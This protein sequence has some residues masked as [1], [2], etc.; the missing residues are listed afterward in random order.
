M[1]HVLNRSAG[2]FNFFRS[3]KDFEAFHCLIVEAHTLHPIRILSYCILSNHWHF[4]VWPQHDGE[5][6]A[7]F[8]WLA[9]TH[10]MRWRV[11]HNTVG[12]GHLYGGRFKSFP[13]EQDRSLLTVCRY[14][15]RN[16][17]T[18]NLVDRAEDWRYG[19][20]Y[21][22]D[23]GPDDI[24]SILTPWPVARRP[25]WITHVNEPLTPREVEAMKLSFR[26]GRPFGSDRWVEKT[27]AK[28][29]LEHTLRPEGR[30]K[31]Q[32]TGGKN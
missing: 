17:L 20:L 22:R 9:H 4:V 24:R 32:K 7:F 29:D 25:D 6:T 18:A 1:Y 3:V 10:A 13:V 14:V 11:S 27:A 12:Y 2:R 26:R 16:A 19:S 23:H 31:L 5:V 28:L 30:P 8:R 21:V 15:E